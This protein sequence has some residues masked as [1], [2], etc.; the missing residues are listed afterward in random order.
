MKLTNAIRNHIAITVTSETFDKKVEA[1]LSFLKQ[2]VIANITNNPDYLTNA[3]APEQ[4]RPFMIARNELSLARQSECDIFITLDFDYY[5]K[6]GSYRLYNNKTTY[7]YD[8]EALQSYQRIKK[9]RDNFNYEISQV[10]KGINTSKKLAEIMPALTKYL[11][12]QDAVNYPVPVAQI[13]RLSA[14]IA[15]AK[16]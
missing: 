14:I 13:D 11:P 10:L 8:S 16:D 7:E 4:F 12:A 5:A 1:A 9:A 15:N 3:T 6:I 2:E